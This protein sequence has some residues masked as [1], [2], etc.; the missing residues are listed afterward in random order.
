MIFKE[1][2]IYIQCRNISKFN[3]SAI[4][5]INISQLFGKCFLWICNMNDNNNSSKILKQAQSFKRVFAENPALYEFFEGLVEVIEEQRQTIEELRV[6]VKS[7]RAEVKRLRNQLELDSHNSSKPPSSDKGRIAPKKKTVSLRKKT[8]RKPG[9]QKG[10]PGTTLLAVSEPDNVE[11]HS[12]TFCS[13]CGEELSSTPCEKIDKRQVFDI[14]P[15]K[16]LVTEHQA[17]VKRCPACQTINRGVFPKGVNTPV[18][19]GERIKSLMVYMNQYHLIPYQRVTEI[20]EDF[21]GQRISQGTLLNAIKTFYSNLESTEKCIKDKLLESPVVHFDETGLYRNSKRI[22]LHNASTEELTYYF[23]HEKRGKDAMND[24]GIL[25][26]YKG[27]AVHDHWGAY[28]S[29]ETCSHAFCNVHHLRELIRAFEQ[30]DAHWAK[31]MKKLLL[32]IKEKVE[33]T[34]KLGGKKLK[35][36]QIARYYKR[37]HDILS[38]GL[39]TYRV[40]EDIGKKSKRGRKKQSKDKN[41]LDRLMKFETETLRFMEDFRVPFDNNLAERDVRMVKVKQKISGCF[42]SDNGTSA[43]CRIRGFISTIKKQGKNVLNSLSKTFQ[44]HETNTIILP[45]PHPV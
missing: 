28:N 37:Y 20:L 30:D 36:D 39:K 25:P 2:S 4:F 3:P 29:Y 17:E 44:Q 38:E 45:H 32:N 35:D 19:Y 7:L 18:Q 11:K 1:L 40:D 16:I 10:H 8:G 26:E 14:P 27:V 9:G 34:K 13:E 43:F 33:Q 41:L 12:V 42:R 24:A 23:A 31:K 22:W 5:T 15:L 6:E 21:F